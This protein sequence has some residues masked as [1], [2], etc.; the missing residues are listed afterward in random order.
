M[1]RQYIE[2]VLIDWLEGKRVDR[3][4]INP[5]SRLIEDLNLDDSDHAELR[6]YLEK[7]MGISIGDDEYL[8]AQTVKQLIDLVASKSPS[9]QDDLE[10]EYDHYGD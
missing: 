2:N 3:T 1:D 9:S 8:K 10:D 6:L 5:E 7:E 4:L